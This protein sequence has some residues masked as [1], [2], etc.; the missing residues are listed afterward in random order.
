VS[1]PNT[2]YLLINPFGLLFSEMTASSLVKIDFDGNIIDPGTTA[3]GINKTG[4][5]I[6]AA[7]HKSRKDVRVSTFSVKKKVI[8]FF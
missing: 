5:I 6:H 3:L 4:Y 7:I 1:L 8:F 2:N